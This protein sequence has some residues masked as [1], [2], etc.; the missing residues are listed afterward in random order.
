MCRRTLKKTESICNSARS[1]MG[2][3]HLG[4]TIVINVPY[5]TVC[6]KT[7]VNI[8]KQNFILGNR[9]VLKM[10]HHCPWLNTCVGNENHCYFLVFI[11]VSI[12]ASIQSSTLMLKTLLLVLA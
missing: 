2:T 10:D 9:C 11:F 1:A 7:A 8:T 5:R 3:K 12:V 4:F 6:L